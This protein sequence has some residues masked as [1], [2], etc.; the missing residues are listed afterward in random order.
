MKQSISL[1][2]IADITQ[3]QIKK[4]PNNVQLQNRK[5]EIEQALINQTQ[6][7]YENMIYIKT[8]KQELQI[9]KTN[10]NKIETKINNDSR[11]M[12]SYASSSFSLFLND[13][14]KNNNREFKE[15]KQIYIKQQVTYEN[16]AIRNINIKNKLI[17]QE[18]NKT[19]ILAQVQKNSKVIKDE[20]ENLKTQLNMFKIE[21][22][23]IVTSNC[24]KLDIQLI[25]N[26]KDKNSPVIIAKKCKKIDLFSKYNF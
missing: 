22:K 14:N 25:N 13:D 3:K 10:L 1:T 5:W 12:N 11:I 19:L 26:L 8:L 18:I 9:I 24:S 21:K 17:T 23:N 7:Y 16:N 4:N 6:K 20:F 2:N 15:K